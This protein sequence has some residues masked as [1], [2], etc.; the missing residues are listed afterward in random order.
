MSEAGVQQGER[1][2]CP[3]PA[4]HNDPL[5]WSEAGEGQ[6][7]QQLLRRHQFG[8]IIRREELRDRQILRS[9]DMAAAAGV[10]RA[11]RTVPSNS[12][13]AHVEQ[14]PRG[15]AGGDE[16]LHGGEAAID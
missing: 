11:I 7:I 2:L 5:V 1:G 9:W 4:I 13:S 8:Q 15:Q 10:R 16:R 3:I 14:S 6:K 12:R